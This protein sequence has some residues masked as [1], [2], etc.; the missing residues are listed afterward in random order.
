LFVHGVSILKVV[1]GNQP[2]TYYADSTLPEG[3]FVNKNNG[4][5]S[6]IAVSPVDDV[7]MAVRVRDANNHSIDLSTVEVNVAAAITARF[8]TSPP[9]AYLG[10]TYEPPVPER[11]ENLTELEAAQTT[12]INR[13]YSFDEESQKTVDEETFLPPGIQVNAGNGQLYGTPTEPGVYPI[14][15]TA[16]DGKGRKAVV[17]LQG[18]VTDLLLEVHECNHNTHCSAHGDCDNGETPFDGNYTCVC[19]ND[20]SG[21]ICEVAPIL[22]D[23]SATTDTATTDNTGTYVAIGVVVFLLCIAAV[24]FVCSGKERR[25]RIGLARK[26]AEPSY[27]A[28]KAELTDGLLAA[29]ELGEYGL[30][31]ALV[32]LGADASARGASGQLPHASAL[33]DNLKLS[34]QVHLCAIQ[35]LFRAHCAFDAQIGACMRKDEGELVEHVLCEMA[36]SAWRSATTTDTVAHKILEGCIT[37]SLDEAQTV[38]LMEAVLKR[39][40]DLLTRPNA[41]SKTPSEIA[42]MCE[43]KKEIQSR[44]TVVLFER[45]QIARPQNPLYKSPTAEVHECIDLAELNNSEQAIGSN[46][47]FVV[48]LMSNPDLWLRELKTRDALGEAV[49]GSYV[50]AI[51]ATSTDVDTSNMSSAA[52]SAA[53]AASQYA[54]SAS[55]DVRPI[56]TFQTA[57]VNQTRRDEARHLMTEYPY[58]IQMP[59]ADRNL[60][61]IIASERLAEEPL[62]AIRQNSRKVLNLIQDLHSEGVVHGDVKPKNVVRV[63]RNLML[64]DLDMSITVGSSEPPAH[65]NPEKFSGSTAYTAPELH[66]WMADRE[67][68]GFADDGTSPLDKLA[69]PQQIDL[70]SFAVTMYEM[71]SGSPLFQNS[72]DRATPASLA[73]LKAWNGLDGDQLSQIEILHGAADSAA[74]RDVLTWALD[75]TA[76][77]RPKSVEEL[78][79]HAFFDPQGGSMRENFVIN[80]IKRLL[81]VPPLNGEQRIDVN[82]MVSYS[83]TDSKFVLSRLAVELASRVKELWLD[84]LGGEHGMGE[85]A[86]ASMQRGAEKANVII[87][88]V[89]PAYINSVNCGYEMELAHALGK[90]VIPVVLNVPF[91]EWPPQRIG[92]STMANQFA[93]EAGDVKIFVDMSDPVSFFQKFQ[94]ELLPRLS[95]GR[96][97]LSRTG[98]MSAPPPLQAAAVVSAPTPPQAGTAMA[99]IGGDFNIDAA[100]ASDAAAG[101]AGDAAETTLSRPKKGKNK[102]APTDAVL[103]LNE[104]NAVRGACGRCGKPVYDSHFRNK[105]AG[106]YFH[107]TC[108]E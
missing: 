60:N 33:K 12:Y 90:P 84:R 18:N 38:E 17:E 56:N 67:A 26:V 31:P 4:Q 93:T 9:I 80:Q 19:T 24:Y 32:E 58:A 86:K 71:A 54:A 79:T 97:A 76:L 59:L 61:E 87:A 3:F 68:G 85:F 40:T 45:Y 105:E 98:M 101:G 37:G 8:T 107:D 20:Y 70:W 49:A 50:G 57:V 73:K 16:T 94:K 10:M 48:K 29:V 83:W 14:R 55:T 51:S 62:D 30:V 13:L 64:I 65:A 15:L 92:L 74:L 11:A 53:L 42:I 22:P 1:G 21:E 28:T 103:Q 44:F 35:S 81:S 25:Q 106:V 23:A 99:A 72:Y 89:S 96:T 78:T 27:G 39:D 104:A 36:G 69:T 75:A 91:S 108:P 6:G 63:D 5:I 52:A 95:S 82:V 66:Q 102:V 88:V 41:R 2:L 43:G 100:L 34:N 47:R 46:K 77:L 7:I